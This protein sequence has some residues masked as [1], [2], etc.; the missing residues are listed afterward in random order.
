MTSTSQPSKLMT[1]P[2]MLTLLRIALIPFL[3]YAAY[4]KVF[5]VAF[6]LFVSAGVTDI[7][8]G[9]LARRLNQ[10]S[11]LGAV[12]DPGADKVLMVSGYL[13]FTFSSRVPNRIPE[14][15]TFAVF[16]RDVLLVIFAY[17]LYTR[18]Q[19]R[20]F[21]PSLAGKITTLLQVIAL[22]SNMAVNSFG[23]TLGWVAGIFY[24]LA[25][26]LTLYSGF[27]YI[28]KADLIIGARTVEYEGTGNRQQATG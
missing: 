23:P 27:D 15:L 22:A 21:P 14:W 16:I 6:V 10:H 12:L 7:L 20:K 13:F 1:I 25:L 4:Q 24:R 9:Y 17:L 18:M 26:V 11:R 19:F 28:R 5:A 2:N 3:L 8:D